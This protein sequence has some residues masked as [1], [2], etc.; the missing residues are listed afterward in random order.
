LTNGDNEIIIGLRS[1]KAIRFN[2]KA[3]RA[4]GRNAAGVK[5]VTLA[6]EH[7]DVIGMVCVKIMK[8]ASWLFRKMD[9]ENV[10]CSMNTG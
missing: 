7:D 1:G 4:I 9:T 5:G 6:D 2:E 10:L 3:V 8:V